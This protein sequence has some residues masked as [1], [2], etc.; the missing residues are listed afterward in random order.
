MNFNIEKL[1]QHHEF[2]K[3]EETQ[4]IVSL[5]SKNDVSCL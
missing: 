1:F 3:W 5:K 2:I 4:Y